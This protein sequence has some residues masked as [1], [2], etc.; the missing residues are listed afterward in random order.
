MPRTY[1][2]DCSVEVEAWD[3]QAEFECDDAEVWIEDGSILVSYFDAEGIVVLEGIPDGKGGW[4][5][6]ARSRP[7]RATLVP[8]VDDARS[9]AGTIE[10]GGESTRWTLRLS[11]PE[12]T[13]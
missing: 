12:A 3:D 7:R 4:H 1:H 8:A 6:V 5:L 2:A 13:G 11:E 9:F 10:E